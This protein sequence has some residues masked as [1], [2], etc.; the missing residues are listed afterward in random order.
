MGGLGKRD[1]QKGLD[2][3]VDG[4]SEL[5]RSKRL[6]IKHSMA[7]RRYGNVLGGKIDRWGECKG[8]G[9]KFR[10]I[11]SDQEYCSGECYRKS[12][13]GKA[14]AYE[15]TKGYRARNKDKLNAIGTVIK[16]KEE[17]VF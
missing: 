11:K 15:A 17:Y 5:R 1:P 16:I 6:C 12:P 8:C 10:L 2:C 13:Q 14:A 9:D 3:I 7:L 4:C